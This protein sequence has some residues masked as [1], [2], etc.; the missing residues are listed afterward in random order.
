MPSSNN[1]D[2]GGNNRTAPHH[3]SI[4]TVTGNNIRYIVPD[5]NGARK[6][7]TQIPTTMTI[8]IEVGDMNNYQPKT[9][10]QVRLL[11]INV[12]MSSPLNQQL[13]I[14]QSLAK[15]IV[16][17][18]PSPTPMLVSTP[19]TPSTT[20]TVLTIDNGAN[21]NHPQHQLTTISS[22]QLKQ[23]PP[24]TCMICLYL[25][26]IYPTRMYNIIGCTSF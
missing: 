19:L 26:S 16:I 11:T 4:A 25:G 21:Y 20:I 15:I 1:N 10:V 23:Q 6:I 22:D 7:T 5:G 14:H 13:H 9:R 3:H 24:I 18:A 2:D 8:I 12:N 17:I